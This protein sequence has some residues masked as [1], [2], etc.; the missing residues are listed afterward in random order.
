MDNVGCTGRYWLESK[1]TDCPFDTHTADCTHSQDAGVYCQ[2]ECEMTIPLCK[3]WTV[4]YIIHYNSLTLTLVQ[5]QRGSVRLSYSTV[6]L[7]GTLEICSNETWQTICDRCWNNNAA[8]VVCH[9]LGYSR[10]GTDCRN[11]HAYDAARRAS[12][13]QVGHVEQLSEASLVGAKKTIP[14]LWRHSSTCFVLLNSVLALLASTVDWPLCF[15][16]CLSR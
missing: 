5:C 7:E 14:G 12:R 9:Q 6:P 8:A 1:L 13:M 2:T 10:I 3:Q 15:F 11:T 4:H 16:L